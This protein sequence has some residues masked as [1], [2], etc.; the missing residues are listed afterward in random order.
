MKPVRNI[1]FSVCV[2]VLLF[3]S[4]ANAGMDFFQGETKKQSFLEGRY[5]QT[6]PVI[7]ADRFMDGS[8]QDETEQYFA[9][10][11]PKRDSVLLGNAALQRWGIST[12]NIPFGF[13]AYPTFFGSDYLACP[14]YEAIVEYPTTQ[15]VATPELVGRATAAVTTGVTN[16]DDVNWLFALVDRSRNTLSNPAHDLVASP[17]DYPY[18]KE[19]FLDKLPESC[20]YVDLSIDDPETYFAQ[21]FH[22]DHH[23]QISNALIAYNKIMDAFKRTPIETPE[24]R[25]VYPGPFYGSEARSGLI[26]DYADSVYDI[27]KPETDFTVQANGKQVKLTWLNEGFGDTPYKKKSRFSNAYGD[28][29]H[30]DRGHIHIENAKGTGSLLVIG[31]SFTNNM[32]YLFAYSYHDVHIVDPRH[33][34]GTLDSFLAENHVDDA[35]VLMASNTLINQKTLTF[36]AG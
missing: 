9:D 35:V 18:Y 5:Y 3:S 36:F 6:A 1:V 17:A 10:L 30:A 14:E 33:F 28:Y 8:I 24:I 19:L 2:A 20:P 29:F 31:D 27:V 11:I 4:I 22:T 26:I 25:E 7:T 13:A 32:D 15:D 12:A 34:E 16:H 23:C 21:Y